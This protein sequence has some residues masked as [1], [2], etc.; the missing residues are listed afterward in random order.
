[1]ST[2]AG[3]KFICVYPGRA[4][5]V[6]NGSVQR[7]TS[8]SCLYTLTQNVL[9]KSTGLLSG[10]EFTMFAFEKAALGV[11]ISESSAGAY[12]VHVEDDQCVVFVG[13]LEN[14]EELQRTLLAED[15]EVESDAALIGQ[16]YKNK[17]GNKHS[18]PFLGELK[19]SYAFAL[20]DATADSCLAAR[21]ESG[22]YMLFQGVDKKTGGLIVTNSMLTNANDL[23]EIPAG[24]F[25]FGKHRERLTHPIKK[26]RKEVDEDAAPKPAPKVCSLSTEERASLLHRQTEVALQAAERALTG[27]T[28][29]PSAEN[30]EALIS[31]PPKGRTTPSAKGTADKQNSWRKTPPTKHAVLSRAQS[32][33]T[34]ST[35][36]PSPLIN[37]SSRETTTPSAKGTADK[38]NTWKRSSPVTLPVA[39]HVTPTQ[40]AAPAGIDRWRQTDLA[41][42][43]LNTETEYESEIEAN[44]IA[45][46]APTNWAPMAGDAF[47]SPGHNIF[48]YSDSDLLSQAVDVTLSRRTSSQFVPSALSVSR[49][50]SFD[51]RQSSDA[52]L[53]SPQDFNKRASMESIAALATSKRS[54]QLAGPVFVGTQH[55]PRSSLA[56]TA[57]IKPSACKRT[58]SQPVASVRLSRDVVQATEKLC[59]TSWINSTSK[60]ISGTFV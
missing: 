22:K 33:L 8:E 55:T 38:A 59:P 19:G 12:Q 4:V 36:Q 49:G 56:P 26:T 34:T 10:E 51:R 20:F 48:D 40:L 3:A 5:E 23:N 37:L 7:V 11:Q 57:S 50:P 44:E 45:Y 25:I 32:S 39:S 15:C 9:D 13:R 2:P 29:S 52:F 6:K 60:R 21:D 35:S 17:A 43:L 58:T 24:M 1:M 31:T 46:Q 54:L 41:E 30:L 16:M 27:I 28:P 53:C 42:I 18:Y 14:A 47:A